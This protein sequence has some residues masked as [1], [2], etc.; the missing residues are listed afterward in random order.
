MREKSNSNVCKAFDNK[1][2]SNWSDIDKWFRVALGLR[3]RNYTIFPI[4]T[5]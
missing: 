3:R 5:P 4:F 1:S 2:K